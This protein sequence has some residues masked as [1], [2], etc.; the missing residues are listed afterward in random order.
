MAAG[1]GTLRGTGY[2]ERAEARPGRLQRLMG[3]A[4]YFTGGAQTGT[5]R[6]ARI[7]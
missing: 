6:V 3:A 5:R 7:V 2:P 4:A 1:T